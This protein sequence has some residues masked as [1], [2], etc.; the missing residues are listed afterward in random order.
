MIL[1]ISAAPK[2]ITPRRLCG[3]ICAIALAD[4]QARFVRVQSFSRAAISVRLE[5]RHDEDGDDNQRVHGWVAERFGSPC[6]KG[7]PNLLVG[8]IIQAA[9]S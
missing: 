7:G 5:K 1:L 8:R 6:D 9:K 3:N 4:R 2:I